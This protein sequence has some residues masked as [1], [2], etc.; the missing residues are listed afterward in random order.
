MIP[1]IEPDWPAPPNVVALGTTR[2]G[3]VSDAP[4]DS[5]NLGDHVG[6]TAEAVVEN[7]RRLQ[8]A[9]PDAAR[10]QWL[11]QV[12][13]TGVVVAGQVAAPEAD[14]CWSG[15]PG[16]ACAVLTADCLPVLLTDTD[17]TVVAAA[18]AGWRGLC[19][20]VIEATIAALPCAPGALMAWLGPAIGP[21]AFE[22]G[23]EVRAAFLAGAAS[24][25]A[26]FR[27][28]PRAGH[29]FADLGALARQRLAGAGVAAVYGG[30]CCTFSEPERFFSYRRDGQTGRMATLICLT[31]SP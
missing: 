9:L 4:W 19:A 31:G 20:G 12:H 1:L 22:V 11:H 5:L 8:R 24:A 10:V 6:D 23:A 26:C 17:G 28:S 29:Y 18:H 15:T 13:G 14:A 16:Q 27:P 30:G 7:R 3:G 2:Q 21:S 25:E